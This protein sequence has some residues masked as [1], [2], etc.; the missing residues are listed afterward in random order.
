MIISGLFSFR[1][2]LCYRLSSSLFIR[3]YHQLFR[4]VFSKTSD[5]TKCIYFLPHYYFTK[6]I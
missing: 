5:T 4:N 3:W 2:L 6:Y 1:L